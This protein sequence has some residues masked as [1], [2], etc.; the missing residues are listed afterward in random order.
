MDISNNVNNDAYMEKYNEIADKTDYVQ[1]ANVIEQIID[2]KEK[3]EIRKLYCNDLLYSISEGFVYYTEEYLKNSWAV[4][5]FIE[6]VDKLPIDVYYYKA[7]AYYFNGNYEKCISSIKNILDIHKKKGEALFDESLLVELFI[8]PFKNAFSGFWDQMD[9]VVKDLCEKDGTHELCGLMASFYACS[10]NDKSI[11]ILTDYIREYS[12]IVTAREYVGTLYYTI[13]R[14]NNVIAAFEGIET[15]MLYANCCE[16]VYFM[17]AWSYGKSRD[18]KNEELYYRKALE[19]NSYAVFANNNLAY[20]LYRQK[21]FL[22]AKEILEKCIQEKIDMPNAANNYVSVLIA[23]GR[24]KDAKDFIRQTDFHI[25]KSLR[26]KVKKLDN[27]NLS[28]KSQI[29]VEQDD[30]NTEVS[31]ATRNI[32][33]DEKKHQFTSERIFED[34]LSSRIEKGIPVFGLDLKVY[35]RKGEYGRQY[36]IPIGRLDLLCEDDAGNLY[37]IELKKDSGYDD[38]YRQTAEYLDWFEKSTKF[39]DR[40]IYGIICLNNPTKDLIDKVHADP[41]MKLFEYSITYKEL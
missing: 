18:V 21:R 2:E 28:L 26:E 8:E 23:L 1:R 17:L 20:N 24:N 22:E 14:W 4:K 35:K 9:K 6:Q 13:K 38:A 7:V 36:I 19:I 29:V 3:L 32:N 25:N 15:P 16:E 30:Q 33:I 41:R 34:E 10:D 37:V 11:D 5:M 40:N 39:N 27:K 31:L 12:I